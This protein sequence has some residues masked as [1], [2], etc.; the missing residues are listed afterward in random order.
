MKEGE[1]NVELWGLLGGKNEYYGSGQNIAKRVP[2]RLFT[3]TNATGVVTVSEALYFS[4]EDLEQGHCAI[5]D[6][7][8]EVYV[9]FGAQAVDAEKQ[10]AMETAIVCFPSSSFSDHLTNSN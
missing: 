8:N 4:Q 7:F 9:W 2:P 3:T 6:V 1:E 5:L 10:I